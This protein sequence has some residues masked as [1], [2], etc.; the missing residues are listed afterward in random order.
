MPVRLTLRYY[1]YSNK[2]PQL[3]PG[4]LAQI[5]Y[6]FMCLLW[7]TL[8]GH[9]Y[10][11]FLKEKM[12]E[13][14]WCW[15]E[16]KFVHKFVGLITQYLQFLTFFFWSIKTERKQNKPCY[17]YEIGNTVPFCESPTPTPCSLKKNWHE[18]GG[19][20]KKN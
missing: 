12:Q 8:K 6:F 4:P 11:T 19:K 17:R 9:S 3:L 5:T 1:C 13:K 15:I 2:D 18:L 7:I 20:K 14:K 10:I 16:L